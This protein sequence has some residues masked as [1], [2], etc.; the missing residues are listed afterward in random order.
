MLKK[1]LYSLGAFLTVSALASG[2]AHAATYSVTTGAYNGTVSAAKSVLREKSCSGLNWQKLTA[3]SLAVAVWEGGGGSSSTDI[4]PMILSRWDTWSGR[5]DG[6]NHYL[7]SFDNYG[8]D[9]RAHYNPGVGLWQLDT[10]ADTAALNHRERALTSVGGKAVA[11]YLRD[12]YCSGT[13]TLKRRLSGNWFACKNNK[14]YNTY[15][16]MYNN[17]NLRV[18]KTSGTEWDGGITS[19]RCRYGNSG[20]TFSCHWYN[21][22]K[23]QGFMDKQDVNGVGARSPL[24]TAFLT[25]TR[26]NTKRSIWLRSSGLGKEIRKTVDLNGSGRESRDW[27]EG[28]SLQVWKNGFWSTWGLSM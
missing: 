14:C 12:G 8:G 5:S 15:L 18:N 26:S 16:D 7:Y 20:S 2:S 13:N 24:A 1:L 25:F 11:R 23:S 27:A 21:E 6:T 4:S 19:H 9:K 3:L 22:R 10:W 17:G 28:T